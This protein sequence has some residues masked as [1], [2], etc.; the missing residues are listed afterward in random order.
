MRNARIPP[1]PPPANTGTKSQP[2]TIGSNKPAPKTGEKKKEYIRLG[3]GLDDDSVKVLEMEG[4]K[5]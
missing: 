2:P 1:P 3:F 5:A 4:K